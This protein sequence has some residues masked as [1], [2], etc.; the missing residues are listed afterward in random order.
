MSNSLHNYLKTHRKRSALTQKDVAFLLGGQNGAK[1]SEYEKRARRPNLE[2]AL[3]CQVVYGV[4]A[5]ELFEGIYKKVEQEVLNRANLLAGT[6]ANEPVNPYSIHKIES[7]Q[8]MNQREAEG[9][10]AQAI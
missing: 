4:P 5:H 8:Q 3:A 6:I 10:L 1:V 9:T 7:L 2:T